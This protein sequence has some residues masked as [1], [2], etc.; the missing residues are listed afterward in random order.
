M[1]CGEI[2]GLEGR[3]KV[4]GYR[5]RVWG[6]VQGVKDRSKV[7][8]RSKICMGGAIP[9]SG[10]QVKGLRVQ[11]RG[12][13]MGVVNSMVAGSRSKVDSSSLHQ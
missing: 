9:R 4:Q 10:V 5:G 2:Q 13:R 6:Q 8:V 11:I 12:Q 1:F 3:S 7:R